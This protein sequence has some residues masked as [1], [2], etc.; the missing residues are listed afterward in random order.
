MARFEDVIS[1]VALG[2][3]EVEVRLADVDDIGLP[4]APPQTLRPVACWSI[5]PL[6]G[7]LVCRWVL[8]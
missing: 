3:A 7:R 2:E 4:D 1:T 8:A 6:T 5:D